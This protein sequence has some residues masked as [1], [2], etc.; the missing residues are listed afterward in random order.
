MG[1]DVGIGAVGL[2]T[3]YLTSYAASQ[4]DRL[5]PSSLALVL[6]LLTTAIGVILADFLGF[7]SH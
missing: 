1:L 3:L 6:I 4:F 5:L 7:H 2:G